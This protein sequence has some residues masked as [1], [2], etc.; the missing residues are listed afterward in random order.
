MIKG[1]KTTESRISKR[2]TKEYWLVMD[3][4]NPVGVCTS[5]EAARI[6]ASELAKEKSAGL[7][8]GTDIYVYQDDV[9]NH[10]ITLQL[11]RRMKLVK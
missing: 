3:G 1:T 7:I 11:V 4:H 10:Y 9:G 6:G 2:T 5:L 8:D